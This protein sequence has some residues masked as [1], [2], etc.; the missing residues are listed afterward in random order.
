MSLTGGKIHDHEQRL[1]QCADPAR[2]PAERRLRQRRG[3]GGKEPHHLR[4]LLRRGN[5][6]WQC[7]DSGH[8]GS[9]PAQLLPAGRQ[10]RLRE[11]HLRRITRS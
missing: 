1:R 4:G 3:V 7:P 9:L 10:R 8:G 6:R 11:G 2:L 5:S